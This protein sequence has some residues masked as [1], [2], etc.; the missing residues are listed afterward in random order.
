M[1]QPCSHLYYLHCLAHGGLNNRV[2]LEN[3]CPLDFGHVGGRSSLGLSPSLLFTMT[4]RP[5]QEGVGRSELDDCL[6][7]ALLCPGPLP[8]HLGARS[9]SLGLPLFAPRPCLG[10]A[11]L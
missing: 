10:H 7:D 4:L 1:S 2:R 8:L 6:T 3:C 11:P 5:S 9:R